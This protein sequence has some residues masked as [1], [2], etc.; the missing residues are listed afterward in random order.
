MCDRAGVEAGGT[1]E[2]LFAILVGVA[3]EVSRTDEASGDRPTLVVLCFLAR[4]TAGVSLPV[5]D[6]DWRGVVRPGVI[7]RATRAVEGDIEE[8]RAEVG[9]AEVGD[10]PYPPIEA[11]AFEAEAAVGL[12]NLEKAADVDAV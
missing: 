9:R 11:R 10:S 4:I 12:V 7:D 1:G 2:G 8:E 3:R 5:V 6:V